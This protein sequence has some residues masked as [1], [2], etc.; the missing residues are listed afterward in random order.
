MREEDALGRKEGETAKQSRESTLTF[1]GLLSRTNTSTHRCFAAAAAFDLLLFLSV[2]D[3][4][5]SLL[6]FFTF[7]LLFLSAYDIS[8]LFMFYSCPF[9]V[10]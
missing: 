1:T 5:G 10:R 8:V 2:S 3:A 7:L 9:N 6:A 4:A